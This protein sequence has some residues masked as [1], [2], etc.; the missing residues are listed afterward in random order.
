VRKLCGVPACLFAEV[1]MSSEGVYTPRERLVLWAVA[2]LSFVGLNGA[3][4]VTLVR[5]PEAIA[6]VM[7]NPL[8]GAFVV[9]A[10]V[11]APVLGYLLHRWGVTRV[12]WGW[13][14]VLSLVGSIGFALPVVVLL[15]P[16]R[17]A[18]ATIS[19]RAANRST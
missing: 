10:L 18:P 7:G 2:I 1:V 13:F 3:F 16:G 12:R 5:Q 6:T 8:A 15:R 11:L 19:H 9:E 14:V 4:L 17:L